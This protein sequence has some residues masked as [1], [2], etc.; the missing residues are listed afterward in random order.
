MKQTLD[1]LTAS[2]SLLPEK[3]VM[4]KESS[5]LPVFASFLVRGTAVRLFPG[6]F[7]RCWFEENILSTPGSTVNQTK[8]LVF[9]DK[10]REGFPVLLKS[11]HYHNFSYVAHFFWM[12]YST[13]ID[14]PPK[15]WN[16]FK[17]PNNPHIKKNH[18]K[19]YAPKVKHNFLCPKGW[20][21][22]IC[23]KI[24]P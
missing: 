11:C 9:K 13:F 3:M 19:D 16:N 7:K 22:F 15:Q 4:E 6:A 20:D 5:G 24:I 12:L 10:P 14:F 18:A 1:S 23:Q 8:W 17:T 21:D 2:N